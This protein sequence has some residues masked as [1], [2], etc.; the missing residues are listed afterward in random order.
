LENDHSHGKIPGIFATILFFKRL[1]REERKKK[2]NS[3]I[4]SSVHCST[5]FFKKKY[6]I[7]TEL[8]VVVHLYSCFTF[9]Y[10]Q[11]LNKIIH[12]PLNF[13]LFFTLH[14]VEKKIVHNFPCLIPHFHFLS[15]LSG[16]FL[17]TH[18]KDGKRIHS[19]KLF[20]FF[21]SRSLISLAITKYHPEILAVLNFPSFYF[22]VWKTRQKV[23]PLSFFFSCDL[24]RNLLKGLTFSH[25]IY[26]FCC[27]L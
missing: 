16:W 24:L 21:V 26:S 14:D 15:S 5:F 23:S 2:L 3:Q 10:P 19:K 17:C 4:Q 12:P 7:E 8:L 11:N 13:F 27:G 9:I 22:F 1:K 25:I 20:F 6:S 18:K